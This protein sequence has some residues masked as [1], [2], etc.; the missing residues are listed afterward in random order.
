M[1]VTFSSLLSV[2]IPKP[3]VFLLLKFLTISNC[4]CFSACYEKLWGR[5]SRYSLLSYNKSSLFFQTKKCLQDYFLKSVSVLPLFPHLIPVAFHSSFSYAP[6]LSPGWR[7]GWPH[8]TQ[9]WESGLGIRIS[10]AAWCFQ[11]KVYPF[12]HSILFSSDDNEPV[13]QTYLGQW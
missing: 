13:G 11:S 10:K 3:L 7:A 2:K 12:K 8:C 5:E 9:C 6:C 1:T 4:R